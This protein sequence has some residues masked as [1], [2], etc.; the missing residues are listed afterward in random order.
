MKKIGIVTMVGYDNYGNLLQNYAVTKLIE[1]MGY[2]AITLNSEREA[3]ELEISKIVTKWEKIRPYYLRRYIKSKAFQLFGCKSTIDFFPIN[4]FKLLKNK[5]EFEKCKEH[6]FK[7]FKE[8]RRRY[9][10]YESVPVD[11]I[12]FSEKDYVAFVCGSDVVWH[13]TYHQN[14]TN[15][16]LGFASQYKRIALAPSF[17]VSQIPED[18]KES[19]IEWLNGI[20]Y[21]SIR[22]EAGASIIKD[23]IQKE[24]EVLPDPTLS[25]EAEH[26][27]SISEKPVTIL[28]K[29]YILCYFLGN[30]TIEY[31]RWIKKCAKQKGKEII[32]V[33]DSNWLQYYATNPSEFLWLI[34][35][36]DSV[37]T[38]S[39]HGVVFSLLFHTPFVAFRRVEEGLSI[40]SR[41]ESLLKCMKMENREFGK[42]KLDQ[43]DKLNFNYVD[44]RIGYLK[45]KEK[46][47]LKN[48]IKEIEEK[49]DR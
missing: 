29:P 39:F 11:D 46:I 41:I 35:H 2:Q 9:I 5:N 23:L 33:Y 3:N 13:P 24:V 17:G 25:V 44:E 19:Y 14:K 15:D 45:E 37:F 8:F 7:K 47:F 21:L 26:W 36:A 32:C 42:T 43:F 49:S 1:D 22:E 48:A 34:D 38:D 27:R 16:F 28:N 20:K 12:H 31:L 10:P 30:V 40:F 6:R 18:R 4:I